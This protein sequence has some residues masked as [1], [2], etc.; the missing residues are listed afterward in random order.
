VAEY[1]SIAEVLALHRE[2]M[3]RMDSNAAPLRDMGLLESA[4]MRPQTTAHYERA[5]LVRQSALLAIGISQNQ[6]FLDGNKRTAFISLITFIGMNGYAF[7]GN[8]MELARQLERVAE[9]T[10]TLDEATDSFESR[11][12]DQIAPRRKS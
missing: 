5:D 1:L 7:V 4:L 10:G 3:E 2:I 9:R 8:P 6:P 11:L 12:R